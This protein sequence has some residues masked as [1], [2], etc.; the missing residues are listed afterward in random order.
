MESFMVERC[1]ENRYFSLSIEK[2]GTNLGEAIFRRF[3]H[4]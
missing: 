3:F 4:P 2:N 1:P